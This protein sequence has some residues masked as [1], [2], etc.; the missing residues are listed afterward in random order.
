MFES[1]Y[2]KEELTRISRKVKPVKRPP[3]YSERGLCIVERDLMIG[4]FILRRL[5]ELNKVSS[6][7]RDF[8]MEVYS[9]P[10][11]GIDITKL[12]VGE[13]FEIYDF[14]NE[15]IGT[16]KPL[17]ISNQFIHAYISFV[18]RDESRNWSDVYIVSD[19]DRNDCIW[20]IP[21]AT[22]RSLFKLA[23]EDYPYQLRYSYD[24]QK[25][26]YL[27]TTD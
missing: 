20:R 17:Y 18:S 1:C 13:I 8:D 6:R 14:E 22:I 3:R 11:R 24:Y 21:I 27:V 16:K 12:N 25:R 4:F 5:L 10:N 15:K 26:D 9:C 19:Y 23:S 2:W 7:T